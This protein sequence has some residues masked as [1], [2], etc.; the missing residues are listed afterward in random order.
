M[1]VGNRWVQNQLLNFALEDLESSL[2]QMEVE[3]EKKIKREEDREARLFQRVTVPLT[4]HW[5]ELVGRFA[6]SQIHAKLQYG[7]QRVRDF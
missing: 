5:V 2:K 6:H 4:Q 3:I 7:V 1:V